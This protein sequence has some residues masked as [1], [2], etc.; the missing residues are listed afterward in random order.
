[1][2]I[3]TK[4]TQID[5][6]LD[7][8]ACHG[9]GGIW[10]ALATGIFASSAINSLGADGLIYGNAGLMIIQLKAIVAVLVYSTVMTVIILKVLDATMGLRVKDEHEVE[11]LDVSQHGEKAYV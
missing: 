5:D 2:H 1:M 3:R 7:V 9:V 10:G 8:M 11:G 4:K 6:S